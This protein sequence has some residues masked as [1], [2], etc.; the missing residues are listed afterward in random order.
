[1]YD[2]NHPVLS[3]VARNTDASLANFAK[4]EDT[5]TSVDLR[6]IAPRSGTQ[7][8]TKVGYLWTLVN[9]KNH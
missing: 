4:T 7:I 3:D 2:G 9:C 1:M 8:Q 6:T 5:T